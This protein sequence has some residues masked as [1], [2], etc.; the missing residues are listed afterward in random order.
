MTSHMS[1]NY[2]ID[3]TVIVTGAAQGLGAAI[4]AG[5]VNGGARVILTDVNASLLSE[6]AARLR[7]S[8]HRPDD[9][10]DIVCD[11]AHYDAVANAVD[12][13]QR[14]FG[15]VDVLVNNAAIGPGWVKE[16]FMTNPIKF[17]EVE[18][19]KWAR[20]L[21]VNTNGPFYFERAVGPA[22]ISKGWGR[23]I[24]VTT[25]FMTMLNFD[26]YGP[27]KAAVEAHTA[28]IAKQ[29][30]GTGVTANIVIPDGPADTAQVTSDIGVSRDKLLPPSVMVPPIL[31]L[32]SDES[33]DTSS[34]RF[35]ASN[36]DASL[37]PAEAAVRGST[38]VAWPDLAA[39]IRLPD[40]SNY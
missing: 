4:A 16:K 26:V 1:V 2:K 21:A 20:I 14:R 37:P 36:W 25:T 23:I 19:E 10:L 3:R 11:Q 5:F 35:S 9:I 6:T 7:T 15:V 40:G 22:M 18:P 12:T 33:A 31:W 32:A 28:I 27:A 38:P 39:P 30:K 13:A 17:W 24:N 34:R 8:S 29:L